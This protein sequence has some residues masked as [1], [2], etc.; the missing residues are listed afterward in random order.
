MTKHRQKPATHYKF[1]D[2]ILHDEIRHFEAQQLQINLSYW[3]GLFDR[4]AHLKILNMSLICSDHLLE[5]ISEHCPCLEYLNATSKETFFPRVA[6]LLS[7]GG[8]SQVSDDGLRTLKAC[9]RLRELVINEPRERYMEKQITY[10]SLRYL[11][12]KIPSLEDISYTDI[13]RVIIDDFEDVESLNLRI[14]RHHNPTAVTLRKAFRLCKKIEQLNLIN[15]DI[16]STNSAI[17]EICQTE[18]QLK[19]IDFQN[20]CFNAQFNRFFEKF[21]INL[22][23]VS[24]SQDIAEIDLDHLITIG[25]HCPNITYLMCSVKKTYLSINRPDKNLRP[26]S[27]LRSLHLMGYNIEIEKLLPFC[28]GSAD[29]L[30]ILSLNELTRSRRIVDSIILKSI[31]SKKLHQLDLGGLVLTRQG[32]ENVINQFENLNSLATYCTEDCR[33]IMDRMR[34][35]NFEFSL[36]LM[37]V[38]E[39]TSSFDSSSSSSWDSD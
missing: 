5:L 23:S 2:C 30:E 18:Y 34:K 9:Q 21:G 33:D 37:R 13:V 10:K 17:E 39:E 8:L 36:R 3:K 14:I 28:T 6:Y 15:W 4:F 26:F 32:I 25:T 11:L 22:K 35:S 12:R 27:Q 31:K 20:I 1:L 7:S 16:G 38:D 24:L 29:K 19:T